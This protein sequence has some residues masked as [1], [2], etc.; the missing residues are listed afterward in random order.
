MR[1]IL[2]IDEELCNG[3]GQ[4]VPACAEEAIQIVDGKARLTSESYCDGLGACLGECPQGAIRIVEREAEAFDP[5]AVEHH[6]MEKEM[7]K[8]TANNV[9]PSSC[10]SNRVQTFAASSGENSF[11][12]SCVGI[13]SALSHWPVQTRLVPPSAP[14]LKG[15][16]LLIAADCTPIAYPEFHN[17]FLKGRVVM[18]GCPK[19]DD[20]QLYLQKFTEIFKTAD[21]KSIT[22]VVMEVPCCQGLLM[23]ID[24]A[25]G[26]AGKNI[27][28]EEITL[29]PEGKII[30]R[31]HR[32]MGEGGVHQE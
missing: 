2:E 20:A 7:L 18:I 27:P 9:A 13:P 28:V 29:S 6:L 30:K 31:G 23:I 19:F 10:P 32:K 25:L 16:D 22:V 24:K 1:K 3:C 5:E 21:I 4:C 17:N 8:K 15:A 14:F 11:E 26:S 12:A